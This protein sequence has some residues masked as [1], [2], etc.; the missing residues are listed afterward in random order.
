MLFK[1]S[2][3][4]TKLSPPPSSVNRLDNGTIEITFIL[5]WPQI[6][7][8]HE[9]QVDQAVSE[10]ELP[11]FRK[12]HAPH[13]LVLPKLD[14]NS[15]Y[16]K[17]LEQLVPRSYTQSLDE[18]QLKPILHPHI[19]ISK[20]K[21]GEDWELVATT[22]EAPVVTLPADYLAEIKKIKE[23]DKNK[24]LTQSVDYLRRVATLKIPTLLIEEE[25]NH[26]LGRLAENL[27]Q[28]S[29]DVPRYLQSKKMTIEDLRA[30]TASQAKIDL[31]IEFILEH[32]RA[33]EK[34]ADRQKTLDFLA[35][36]V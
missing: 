24:K 3:P 31:E 17:A 25:A 29:L 18:H 12:G 26:R 9:K 10:A 7:T 11:G 32:I 21:I 36:I 13:D 8:A 16:Q 30:Q 5:P 6:Q 4:V 33:T 15:L 23:S 28:L 19:K 34:L 14:Q 20:G 22:C 2:P 35:N 1:T 27:A